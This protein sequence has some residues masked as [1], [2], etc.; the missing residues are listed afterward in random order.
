MNKNS[1]FLLLHRCEGT[2][3]QAN[4]IVS[5]FYPEIFA[6]AN[7]DAFENEFK[8]FEIKQTID[9]CIIHSFIAVAKE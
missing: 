1:Y 6:N 2:S 4:S 9:V 7:E 5:E 3:N 8:V